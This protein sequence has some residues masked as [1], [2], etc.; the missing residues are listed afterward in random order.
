MIEI[1]N[2]F[3]LLLISAL[4]FSFP[5]NNIYFKK[6]LLLTN[7]NF[8]EICSLN[9]L[10]ILTFFLI[11]SFFEINIRIIFLVFLSLSILNFFLL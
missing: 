4:I 5:L 3:Y 9:I 8:F 11:L 10:F 1:L 2:I 6:K 7:L